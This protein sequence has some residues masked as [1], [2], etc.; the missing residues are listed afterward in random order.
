MGQMTKEEVMESMISKLKED[1]TY[2]EEFLKSQMPD[3]KRIDGLIK[4]LHELVE[5]D[6]MEKDQKGRLALVLHDLE[7]LR[8]HYTYYTNTVSRAA[9][10]YNAYLHVLETLYDGSRESTNEPRTVKVV[11][12]TISS[13]ASRRKVEDQQKEKESES[14]VKTAKESGSDAELWSQTNSKERGFKIKLPV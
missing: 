4:D 8:D 13:Q 6:G 9:K 12:E 7:Q 14:K 2:S 3:N 5:D 1:V 11:S 10:D